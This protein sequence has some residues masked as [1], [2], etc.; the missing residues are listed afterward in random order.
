[1]EPIKTELDEAIDELKECIRH[2][3]D[4]WIDGE[5]PD[6]VWKYL[7]WLM[8]LKELRQYSLR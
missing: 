3:N 5:P 1:M 8:E 2:T 7:A 6:A 4:H